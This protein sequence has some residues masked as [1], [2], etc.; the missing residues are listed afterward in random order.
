MSITIYIPISG[1]I[2]YVRS[3]ITLSENNIHKDYIATVK[4]LVVL[5]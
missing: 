4:A 2:I 1:H 3:I 5:K